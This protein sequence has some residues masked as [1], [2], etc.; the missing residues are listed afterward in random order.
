MW[1]EYTYWKK[2]MSDKYICCIIVLNN[3]GKANCLAINC[4]SSD[5][6]PYCIFIY[7]QQ[8]DYLTNE[9]VRRLVYAL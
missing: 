9:L 8:A 7:A 2:E 3:I 1:R 4:Q 6:L 5:M